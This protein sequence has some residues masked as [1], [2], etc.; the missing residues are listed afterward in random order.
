MEARVL[1]RVVLFTLALLPACGGGGGSSGPSVVGRGF[2]PNTGPGDVQH[3]FPDAVGNEWSMNYVATVEGGGSATGITTLTIAVPQV[4]HGTS[5]TVLQQSDSQSTSV[6]ESYYSLRPGGITYLGNDDPSDAVTPY[7]VPQPFLL[8]P[9]AV[10]PVSSV[11]GQHLP[12]GS[13]QLGNA[14]TIDT[15]Q[16]YEVAQFEPLDLFCG[17]FPAALKHVTTISGS[18][19]DAALH[20][21]LPISSSET[22]WFAPGA[23]IVKHA[24]SITVDTI[25]TG[26]TAETRGY[27]VDGARHGVGQLE[28]VF[29]HLVPDDYV[30]PP[31]GVPALASDGTNFLVAARKVTGVY[32][33]YLSRWVVQRIAADGSLMGGSVD[34]GSPLS[35]FDN[36]NQRKAAV[37]FDGVEYIVVY[38]QDEQSPD[39]YYRVSLM[40]VRVSTAGVVLGAPQV[41]AA[42]S[43]AQKMATEPALS[44]DGTRCLVCFVRLEPQDHFRTYGVF[45]SPSTGTADGPEFPIGVLGPAQSAPAL[46]FDGAH[47]L[48]IWNQQPWWDSTGGLV[49]ARVGLD[50]SV[51]DPAWIQVCTAQTDPAALACD[52]GNFLVVWTDHRAQPGGLFSNVYANRISPEGQLLDGDAQ[53]GGFAVTSSI[54]RMESNLA[55]AGFDGGYIAVWLS[56]SSPGVYEGLYGRRLSS[57]GE[58]L[59]PGDGTLLSYWGF[60][61]HVR[62]AAGSQS[63]LLT[64]MNETDTTGATHTVKAVGLHPRGP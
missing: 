41:V 19:T 46:A 45:L 64:W 27:E 9:A 24:T 57:A 1:G 21:T 61:T 5:A 33:L 2:A 25:T 6:F 35:V 13:D 55:L 12:F 39:S 23:G 59:G 58:P 54:G 47:Y 49:G 8:F 32:G 28:T 31:E 34:L 44:F 40:A 56:S 38:E 37:V 10:G 50:G 14:L 60:Q 48:A 17:S 11:T 7:L 51:L 62:L 29:E 18:V 36:F 20:V 15:T 22:I 26:S 42:A 53:T 16:S 30:T 4:V 3:L 52:G 63:S 43:D